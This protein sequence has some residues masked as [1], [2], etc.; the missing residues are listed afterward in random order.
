MSQLHGYDCIHGCT[1]REPCEHQR[2]RRSLGHVVYKS[3]RRADDD[4]HVVLYLRAEDPP[5]ESW[6]AYRVRVHTEAN[7]RGAFG[8]SVTDLLNRAPRTEPRVVRY[9]PYGPTYV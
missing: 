5:A 1:G 3:T 6:E 9:G 8:R 7:A 2:P 4:D